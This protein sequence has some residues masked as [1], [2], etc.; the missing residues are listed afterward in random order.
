MAPLNSDNISRL[1][2]RGRISDPRLKFDGS[3]REIDLIVNDHHVVL[4]QDDDEEDG[5]IEADERDGEVVF[6]SQDWQERNVHT[7]YGSQ[8][9]IDLN[10]DFS[11]ESEELLFKK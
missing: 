10:D 7:T 8:A 2:T 3:H 6:A 11:E 1:T 9:E 4:A 5:E